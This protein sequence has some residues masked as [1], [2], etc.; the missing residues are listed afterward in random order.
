MQDSD[1]F[2]ENNGSSPSLDEQARSLG[3]EAA[4]AGSQAREKVTSTIQEQ[5]AK[6]SDKAKNVAADT[7]AKIENLIDEQRASGASYLQNVA[8]L[9][10]QAA[11][12]FDKEIPQ[13]S[14]YIHQA[15]QQID[16]VAETVRT[17]RMREVADDMQHFAR[18][19]PALFFGGALFLGF[20]AVRVFRANSSPSSQDSEHARQ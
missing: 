8:D 6:I 5:A 19:Q 15:A 16:T 9:V 14:Q 12:V 13:A 11:D 2:K 4:A 10:H 1:V 17:R 20:A 3:R 18:R 7:G